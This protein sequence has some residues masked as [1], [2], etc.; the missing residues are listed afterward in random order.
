MLNNLF[1][2]L[3]HSAFIADSKIVYSLP[4]SMFVVSSN[5][6]RWEVKLLMVSELTY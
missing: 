2:E 6:M 1:I 4:M 3:F 5:V